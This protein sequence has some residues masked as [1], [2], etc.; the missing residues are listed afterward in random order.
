MNDYI[1]HFGQ[2]GMK[3]IERVGG[4]NCSLGE[5]F[6]EMAPLGVG[7]LDG[8]AVTVA[9]YRAL[10]GV[11][12]LGDRIAKRLQGL[13][14]N[15]IPELTACG[16]AIREMMLRTPL[17]D[18]VALSIRNAYAELCARMGDVRE[19][20]V[21]S[22][23]TAEDLPGASF[24]GQQ[25]TFLNIRGADALL[26]AVRRCFASGFTSRAISYRSRHGF[27]HL[28]VGISVGVQPMV[29][30]DLASSGVIFTLDP[31]SGHRG[32]TVVTGSYGLGEFVVQGAV[33]P[34]EWIVFKRGLGEGRL[35]II[36]RTLGTKE[37]K[38]AYADGSK[39][40][41][42]ELTPQA[43]RG[44][45]CLTD[46]EVVRLA[47]WAGLAE[48]HYAKRAGHEMPL[49]IEWAKDGVSGQLYFLQARPETVHANRP[50]GAVA[51]VYAL[52]GAPPEPVVSGQAVGERIGTGKV[53]VVQSPAELEEVEEGDVVVTAETDPD[54]EPVMKRLAAIVTE[55]GGRTSHAAI[56]SR[57]IG[58]PCIVGAAR[59][60]E[61]LSSTEEVTVSCAEGTTGHV[62]AGRLPFT[63]T[64]L[65][66]ERAPATRTQVMLNIADPSKALQIASIPNEG[67]GLARIEFII[68]SQ[69]GIHPM[70]VTAY[71][72]LRDAAAIR[73]IGR[74]AGQEDPRTF[75]VKRLSEG[76]GRIAAAFYPKPVIVRMSDFKTNEYAKLAGG[77]EFEPVEENPMI[78]FRGASRYADP[79]YAAG[80]E[81]ECKAVLRARRLMGLTNI[82]VMIPFCRTVEEGRC[83]IETM[84]RNGLKQGEEGL[85]VFVMCEV[86]SNVILAREFLEV[87]DGMSIGSNDLTQLMLGIDRDSQ[88]I[89]HLFDE[90][91]PAV[92]AMIEQVIGVAREMGKPIGICGQAPSDI[93][94]Y[95]AWLV[96]LGIPS[97]S[98][99]PDSAISARHKIWE[100]E[101]ENLA[102]NP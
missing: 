102:A 72:R 7:V 23:A 27:D 58:L 19:L 49:D 54:W 68:T 61:I 101:Q 2:I 30:S 83:V 51:R 98:L 40:T 87:F 4:K 70:A 18:S 6:N 57:E 84:G 77:E 74:I 52:N 96:S 92:K 73:A 78:G 31:E 28:K 93:P 35:P 46:E 85:E 14:V 53:R 5:L 62:Y 55:R 64:E 56:V 9:A 69:I 99:N 44:K 24:A 75:F 42:G 20:A 21:R 50:S 71:P 17:P 66:P 79:R 63:V 88:T 89:A 59:A 36:G 90:R 37:T 65:A 94:G 3:D 22:S 81:L 45:F 29:R 76:I 34:D 100:A 25:E 80:F 10:L 60:R 86:P 67:V 32:V 82:K 1:L 38:L 97:I 33:N 47:E 11:D 91:N 48:A 39:T 15:N 26:D 41:R 13:D 43:M 16:D 8:F 12:G 95:A